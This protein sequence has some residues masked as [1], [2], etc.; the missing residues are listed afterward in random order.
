[1]SQSQ[2]EHQP[3]L[4]LTKLLQATRQEVFT[5]WMNPDYV[6]QWMCPEGDSVLV[7]ELD[8]RVGGTFR[9]TMRTDRED[10]HTGGRA[11]WRTWLPI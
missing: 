5:A 8:V 4:R 10:M 2:M 9:I 3:T 7:A 11:F 6:L 1:M